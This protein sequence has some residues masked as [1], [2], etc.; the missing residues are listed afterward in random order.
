LGRPIS[1]IKGG[2]RGGRDEAAEVGDQNR[3][4]RAHEKSKGRGREKWKVVLS[5]YATQLSDAQKNCRD[6][7]KN[8]LAKGGTPKKESSTG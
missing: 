8:Q 3:A 6:A 1:R 2:E 7:S 4:A 5:S